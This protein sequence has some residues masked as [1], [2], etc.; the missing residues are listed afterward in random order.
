MRLFEF[1]ECF[2]IETDIKIFDSENMNILYMGKVG[3]IPHKISSR[4]NIVAKSC[5]VEKEVL[6]VYTNYEFI[7]EK[8][9]VKVVYSYDE[10]T[11]VWIGEG[12][13]EYEGIILESESL[14]GLVKRM[15]IAIEDWET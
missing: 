14:S 10:E 15:K 5:K 9:N 7:F 4:K 12:S 1:L 11:K 13:G 2:S 3:D 6:C 8:P